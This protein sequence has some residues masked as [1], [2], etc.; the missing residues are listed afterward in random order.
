MSVIFDRTDEP[1]LTS[2]RAV[3]S[4]AAS[5][6]CGFAFWMMVC[7]RLWWELWGALHFWLGVGRG[8]LGRGGLTAERF[9]ADRF[10][11]AGGRMFRTGDLARWRSD[12]ALE[13]LG[14]VDPQ[15]SYAVSGSS[16]GG[17]RLR[18]LGSE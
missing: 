9:V 3:S 6:I 10:G 8:C 17:S 15:V 1:A 11:P 5:P 12:G 13:V 2:R 16:P 18:C 4:A 14:R 7:S